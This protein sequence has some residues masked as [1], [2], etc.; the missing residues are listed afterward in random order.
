MLDKVEAWFRRFLRVTFDDDIYLLSLWTAHTHLAGECYTTPRL[1]LDSLVEGA[2]KSTV[3]DH[4]KRLGHNP[5]QIASLSSSALLPRLLHSGMRTILLDEVHRTLRPEN[6]GVGDLL[7]IINTGYRAGATRPVNVPAS[8]GG[9]GWEVEEMPTF[10][11]VAMA[12]NDPHLENDTRSRTIRVLLM[13]DLD[14]SIEDT[15]WEY[16]EDEA[17]ALQEEIAQWSA[18]ASSTVKGMVVDLPEGCIGRSKEKWRPL[19]RIAVAAGGRWPKIA[20]RL[21]QNGLKEEVA[22]RAAGLRKQPPGMVLLNDL[23]A[24]WPKDKDFMPT[25]E[26]VDLL[27]RHHPDYWGDNSPYGR[28]LNVTRLGTLLNQATNTTSVRPDRHGRRGYTLA[29]IQPAWTRLGIPPENPE[30]PA[31]S[32]NPEQDT[33]TPDPDCSEL[34]ECAECSESYETPTTDSADHA[35]GN[36]QDPRAEEDR[37]MADEFDKLRDRLTKAAENTN[38]EGVTNA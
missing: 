7:A 34:A 14:G 27:V 33:D 16:L 32:V 17:Q 25:I 15:D 21:I 11:P 3:L 35:V 22:V 12:G 1:L 4:L 31:N 26:L 37:P 38:Q 19:K 13:P 2:G 28:P 20:D 18:S 6:P 9:G 8:G 23:Y 29:A 24:V 5:V 36:G 10:A 30:H